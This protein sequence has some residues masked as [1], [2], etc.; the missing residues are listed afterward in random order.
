MTKIKNNKVILID[1]DVVSH[2]LRAGKITVLTKI[3]KTPIKILDVVYNELKEWKGRQKEIENLITFK[4]LEV[5]AFPQTNSEIAKEFFWIKKS[6]YYGDGEAACMSYAKFTK[7]IIASNNLKDTK[8]YCN[9]HS[10]DYL[11][12]MDFLS[13]AMSE[14]IFTLEDC[15]NFMNKNSVSK[16]PFPVKKMENFKPR[17]ISHIL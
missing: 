6:R 2:F 9:L 10:V 7:N 16:N 3:F 17:N 1:A 15:N 11:T 5:I 8:N 4:L 14:G 12:T 13:R